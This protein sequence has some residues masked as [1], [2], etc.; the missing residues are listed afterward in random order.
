MKNMVIH[1]NDSIIVWDTIFKLDE[2][3]ELNMDVEP[4]HI[5]IAAAS[6]DY[7]RSLNQMELISF[8]KYF[9]EYREIYFGGYPYNA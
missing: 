7:L 3:G 2:T 4:M 6:D 1:S 5:E 9:Q 8:A